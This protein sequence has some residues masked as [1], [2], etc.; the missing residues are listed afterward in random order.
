MRIERIGKNTVNVYITQNDLAIRHLSFSTLKEDSADYTK[1]V[2][3]AID[4]ANI[5]FGREFDDRQLKIVDKFDADGCLILTISHD[6]DDKGDVNEVEH[7]SINHY[8]DDNPILEHFDKILN[9][10]ADSMRKEL[11][12]KP[13]SKDVSRDPDIAPG[14]LSNLFNRMRSQGTQ[15]KPAPEENTPTEDESQ[16]IN[17]TRELPDERKNPLLPDWDIIVFPVFTDMVEFLRRNQSFKRIASS[18]YGYRGAYYLLLK[19]NSKNANAVAR[20]EALAVDYNATYLP[21]ESFLPLL[22]ERGTIIIEKGAISRLIK[23]FE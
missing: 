23:E 4:H 19:P 15:K 10:A 1:L 6:P 13:N 21:S 14:S 18:L 8:D 9:A 17:E 12:I 20:L 2:W 5:E 7:Y 3:D 16:P 22:L 11:G